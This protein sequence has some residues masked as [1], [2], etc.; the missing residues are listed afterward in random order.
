MNQAFATQLP[1]MPSLL[2][3]LL[4][5]VFWWPAWRWLSIFP[6][7][8]RQ[9]WSLRITM[10]FVVA[11][12]AFSLLTGPM[13]LLHASSQTAMTCVTVVWMIAAGVAEVLLRKTPKR[14]S[15][16]VEEEDLPPPTLQRV[17]GFIPALLFGLLAAT[18]LALNLISSSLALGLMALSF[19]INLLLL[20]R[21]KQS[22]I[23][24]PPR[25]HP[26]VSVAFVTLLATAIVTPAFHH[27]ADADDN[28]YLSEALLLQDA[29]AMGDAAPTHRGEAL[30][31]NPVYAWQ[32]FELWGAMLARYSGLHPLIVLR[33]FVGPILLLLSLALYAAFLRRLLPD[34]LV[35]VAMVFLI[36]Y[37][38]FG[39]SSH[40]T[41]NNY[42][43]TRPQ[44]GKTWLMHVGILAALWQSLQYWRS[45]QPRD[46]I[47]LFLV[48]CACMGWAP[49]ALLLVPATL[50]TFTLVQF[51]LK[52]HLGT[53]KRGLALGLCIL[54]QLV[55]VFYLQLQENQG[56]QDATLGEHIDTSWA[57]LFFFI[58]L[59]LR[60]GGGALEI[61][62]LL[63]APLVL[64][65]FPQN[66]PQAY[67]VLFLGGLAV[68]LLN[69]LFFPFFSELAGGIWGYL[70]LFWLLP[71]P[72]LFAA[73]GACVYGL[74]ITKKGSTWV[75]LLSVAIVLA[76]MPL[77]GA[78][79]VWS[80]S[81][82]YSPEDRGIVLYDVENPFKIPQDLLLLANEL[83]QLPLGPD[84]RILAHLNEVTHLAPLVKAFDFVYARDFQTPPPLIAL[85]REEEAKRR[86]RLAFD[87]LAGNMKTTD[88]AL[89]LQSELTSYVIVSPYT[90]DLS[91]P[92]KSL[93]YSLRF[94]SGPYELWVRD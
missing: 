2:C 52:P 29:P 13:L 41:P 54:P 80:S 83:Q 85:G 3:L 33:S 93:N 84:H 19:A 46:W 91:T 28:L 31:A 59:K 39:S 10:A 67:P 5:I 43:L 60:S 34:G 92:L 16:P 50:G 20:W 11:F 30:P 42:L 6:S 82:L 79:Y 55:F 94:G 1:I 57:D 32:S 4:V 47:L 35:P 56:L 26:L 27:R 51:F 40:W 71:L 78:H 9:S 23:A 18:S 49:T 81:N 44:Q 53:I 69:P 63:G 87:F 12:G 75:P 8:V 66:R 90:A 45:G 21:G 37:F 68:L 88:A 17:S 38:L 89:L 48:S 24:T 74:C 76:A 62:A 58:F 61:F 25:A 86:E 64:L 77:C 22:P 73:L 14:I 15:P 70:R 72:L 7:C 36:A 65:A